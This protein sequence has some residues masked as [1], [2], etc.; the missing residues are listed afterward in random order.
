MR[1]LIFIDPAY[2]ETYVA[3]LKQE[4]PKR[5][6][7]LEKEFSATPWSAAFA[8]E[9]LD[10]EDIESLSKDL[11]RYSDSYDALVIVPEAESIESKIKDVSRDNGYIRAL[12][13]LIT[14]SNAR[15]LP[16]IAY[17]D[18]PGPQVDFNL[19]MAGV[20]SVVDNT[21]E[22]ALLPLKVAKAVNKNADVDGMVNLGKL[23]IDMKSG[24]VTLED[25]IVPFTSSERGIFLSLVRNQGTVRSKERLLQEMYE[26]D[27]EPEIKI[28][29]VFITKIR[30]KI[31]EASPGLGFDLIRTDWGGGYTVPG[32]LPQE[33]LHYGLLRLDPQDDGR[34]RIPETELSLG[35]EEF[36][37][38]EHLFNEKGKPSDLDSNFI[39]SNAETM[40][41]LESILSG[42]LVAFG[43]ALQ[44]D[45]EENTVR[46]NTNYFDIE[47]FTAADFSSMLKQEIV[48]VG[49]YRFIRNSP[50]QYS[51][52]NTEATFTTPE[53]RLLE[54]LYKIPQQAIRARTLYSNIR[55][56]SHT[57]RGGKSMDEDIIN[58]A[59]EV[60][61]KLEDESGVDDIEAKIHFYHDEYLSFGPAET[62]PDPEALEQERKVRLQTQIKQRLETSTGAKVNL[63]AV[64]L[65]YF[66]LMVH[67]TL[68]VSMVEGKNVTFNAE[69]TR[70]MQAIFIARPEIISPRKIFEEVY[71]NRPFDQQRM[72]QKLTN[73]RKILKDTIPGS[74]ALLTHA[75]GHGYI[76][77]LPGDEVPAIVVQKVASPKIVKTTVEVEPEE[78]ELRS[79]LILLKNPLTGNA[80]V[81]DTEIK[82]R[83]PQAEAL[84]F[85]SEQYPRTVYDQE[86][87]RSTG[88]KGI[89]KMMKDLE[90]DWKLHSPFF[91][92][93]SNSLGFMWKDVDRQI[94]VANT[95]GAGNTQLFNFTA[96]NGFVRKCIN[97]EREFTVRE[98]EILEILD[99]RKGQTLDGD[100]IRSLA[101]KFAWPDNVIAQTIVNVESK[102]KDTPAEGRLKVEKKRGGVVLL[103]LH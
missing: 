77:L 80:K 62:V 89:R 90:D 32:K 67:P 50:S 40:E 60:Y 36:Q 35:K 45:V 93:S 85:L 38:F 4:L 33:R 87:A 56:H 81:K 15:G 69:Q 103:T 63:E 97:L 30:R 70:L 13:S 23:R 82:L 96:A 1:T 74:E 102:I 22:P 47:K 2:D 29:D 19:T 11:P 10:A 26:F 27:A 42:Y 72:S 66:T 48:A 65:G 61:K 44:I 20:T 64:D 5:L 24:R 14:K 75:R 94:S 39:K 7:L 25:K 52:Q 76:S 53:I 88:L 9:E 37:L 59:K 92:V 91:P 68:K 17:V 21:S 95:A 73:L 79:G 98:A 3:Y 51:L 101:S 58:L 86:L 99:T 57:L 46:L 55:G 49:P 100:T 31:N 6:K 18:E 54:N 41:R 83:K 12:S 84:A 43:P 8:D 34:Y 16:V 78:V 28:V 71:P